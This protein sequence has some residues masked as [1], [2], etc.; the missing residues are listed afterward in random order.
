MQSSQETNSTRICHSL[1]CPV[2]SCPVLTCI[3]HWFFRQHQM[4]GV[5]TAHGGCSRHQNA[6]RHKTQL[7][8]QHAG[9][10]A[11][12][13]CAW[14]CSCMQP[15]ESTGKGPGQAAAAAAAAAFL[16]TWLCISAMR[17]HTYMQRAKGGATDKTCTQPPKH[18]LT[19]DP[20]PRSTHNAGASAAHP[21]M[22]TQ[23][24]IQTA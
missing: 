15:A 19:R 14:P 22:A 3:A 12:L 9:K 18:A 2:L 10:T 17:T 1:S 16:S 13:L 24:L 5:P 11:R 21:T 23:A 4:Q 6:C 20:F 8:V 7:S